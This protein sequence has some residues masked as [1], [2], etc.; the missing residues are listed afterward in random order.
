[1]KSPV[2]PQQTGFSPPTGWNA[3][4]THTFTVSE[5]DTY[6][7]RIYGKNWD[8]SQLLFGTLTLEHPMDSDGDGVPDDQDAFPNDPN[9][10]ADSD[11]DGVGDNGDAFPNDP[12]EQSDN[13]NDGTGD[14]ADT[15]DDNDGYSD[16]DEADNGTDPLDSGSTP[17]DYDGDFVSDLN[18]PDDDNDGVDD[19]N[20]AYPMSDTAATV[21]I[22]GEDL[23][24]DNQV[25]SDG[26][27][28]NDLIG[29]CA[30]GAK[31]HGKFV[32]CVTQLAN[33]W[34]KDGLISGR[35]SG[36][37]TSAAARSS[38]PGMP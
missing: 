26:S 33:G 12:N 20:D 10:S 9:E 17:P 23:G 15:D 14:N 8:Y 37:I 13:D 2:I 1:V 7:F 36:K 38:I 28:F 24:I 21:S 16:S 25:L 30:A 19:E 29:T 5:G 3:Q 32:Q 34:R 31:N 35:D 18:D 6:G 22:G 11:N 4:G 27:T